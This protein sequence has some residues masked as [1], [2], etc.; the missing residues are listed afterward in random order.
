M[1]LYGYNR[2]SNIISRCYKIIIIAIVFLLV[3][4]F[5]LENSSVFYRKNFTKHFFLHLNAT[6][7]TLVKG[8]E[9]HLRLFAINKRVTFSTTNFRVADVNFNG[10][11][12]AFNTGKAYILAKVDK[13]VLKCRVR[14]I[15]I[16]K[17]KLVIKKGRSKKLN[18]KG[19]SFV[20]WKS[21]NPRVA[22]VTM[23]GRV[24]TKNKG[25]T[26]ITAKVRG[27]SLRCQVIV[28]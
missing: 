3:S 7:I 21:S 23:F 20:R 13:K 17:K 16:S 18:I 14:V 25:S 11:I 1:S 2:N 15:D 8:E 12:Y 27:K 26:V 22:K 10:R 28:K 24:Y 19:A 5:I 9:F 6:D 4:D